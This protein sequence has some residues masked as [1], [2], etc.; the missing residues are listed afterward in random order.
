MSDSTLFL[1]CLFPHL[2]SI[3][4]KVFIVPGVRKN[5]QGWCLFKS[6]CLATHLPYSKDKRHFA[7]GERRRREEK[8]HFF[9]VLGWEYLVDHSSMEP[10]FLWELPLGG[11]PLQAALCLLTWGRHPLPRCSQSPWGS[12]WLLALPGSPRQLQNSSGHPGLIQGSV[13]FPHSSLPL[14]YSFLD[15]CRTQA[16]SSPTALNPQATAGFLSLL[17]ESQWAKAEDIS[18]CIGIL[19]WCTGGGGQRERGCFLS[20]VGSASRV[21]SGKITIPKHRTL[22]QTSSLPL[23]QFPHGYNRVLVFNKRVVEGREIVVP[24]APRGKK[25]GG[26]EEEEERRRK[27]REG[28]KGRREGEKEGEEEDEEMME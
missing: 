4:W 25:N 28:R 1:S 8:L 15:M 19:S 16:V 10:A 2:G 21:V 12:E 9:R 23:P 26:G 7:F 6:N 22:P 13:S 14:L 11:H 27:R 3:C 20:P 18:L 24:N 5:G 17:R